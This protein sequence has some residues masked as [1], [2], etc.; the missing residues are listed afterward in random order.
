LA[1]FLG[2]E[3]V[4][5]LER[6][7]V[8]SGVPEEFGVSSAIGCV[9]KALVKLGVDCPIWEEGAPGLSGCPEDGGAIVGTTVL[10]HN[11]AHYLAKALRGPRLS[12]SLPVLL[13]EVFDP[14]APIPSVCT[15]L[16]MR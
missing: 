1:L 15:E 12:G 10:E 14:L 2:G 7:A 4:Y 6:E 11:G 13:A 16:H 8:L 5:Q 9:L 3:L